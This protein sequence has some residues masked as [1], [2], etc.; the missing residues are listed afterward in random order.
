MSIMYGQYEYLRKLQREQQSVYGG[1]VWKKQNGQNL[2]QPF[3]YLSGI[4]QT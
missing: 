1:G 3:S 4:E 2:F